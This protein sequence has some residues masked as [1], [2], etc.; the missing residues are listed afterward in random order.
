MAI[1]GLNFHLFD[2]ETGRVAFTYPKVGH[3]EEQLARLA[4]VV[5]ENAT[6]ADLGRLGGINFVGR[7]FGVQTH[8]RELGELRHAAGRGIRRSALATMRGGIFVGAGTSEPCTTSSNWTRSTLDSQPVHRVE[9]Y[10]GEDDLRGGE[11]P[12]GGLETLADGLV[13]EASF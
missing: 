5:G 13:Y 2:A 12:L 4:S 7:I 11:R 10:R 6:T 9:N 8:L 3:H 1:G